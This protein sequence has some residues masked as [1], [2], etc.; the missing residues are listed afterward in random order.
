[1][2]RSGGRSPRFFPYVPSRRGAARP[3]RQYLGPRRRGAS[4][5]TPP[6]K[7]TDHRAMSDR[8]SGIEHA[9]LS[10]E[11]APRGRTKEGAL[12]AVLPELELPHRP[13]G[14][15]R[16]RLPR[17]AGPC[18]SASH[19]TGHSGTSGSGREE[20]RRTPDTLG[21]T[22]HQ[23]LTSCVGGRRGADVASEGRHE[24]R[25]RALSGSSVLWRVPP[26]RP[27]GF[28]RSRA[29]TRFPPRLASPHCELRRRTSLSKRP[30]TGMRGANVRTHRKGKLPFASRKS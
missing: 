25:P 13:R 20:A 14:G 8:Y 10:L 16:A 11:A 30:I 17:S 5:K 18:A 3:I 2:E 15:P 1:M 22:D 7:P 29:P 4:G 24:R 28:V 21:S 19:S 27:A 6:S 26:H 9:H 23:P 12:P